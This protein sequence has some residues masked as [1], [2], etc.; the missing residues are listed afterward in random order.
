MSDQ[1]IVEIIETEGDGV[2]FRPDVP[3]AASGDPL[4][5]KPNDLVVW[6]NRTD[7]RVTLESTNPSGLPLDQTVDAGEAS[8]SQFLVPDVAR[9][10]YRCIDPDQPHAIDV[11]QAATNVATEDQST[12]P[13]VSVSGGE[14]T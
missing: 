7:R 6:S 14:T 11:Q 8:S 9:I 3:G 10:E 1:W 4:I 5:A 2:A 12:S 13:S